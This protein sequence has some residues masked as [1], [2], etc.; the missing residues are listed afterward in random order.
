MRDRLCCTCADCYQAPSN[1][2]EHVTA[3][4]DVSATLDAAIGHVALA[5]VTEDIAPQPVVASVSPLSQSMMAVA[6]G[7]SLDTAG[8]VNPQCPITAV[9]ATAPQVVSE[10]AS[11]ASF[12]ERPDKLDKCWEQSLARVSKTVNCA[13]P[14]QTTD[15]VDRV[16]VSSKIKVRWE[17]DPPDIGAGGNVN[18][19]ATR[20]T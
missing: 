13:T 6:T 17:P 2:T 5:P 8:L 14:A 15:H 3:P 1:A 11:F 20:N 9:K 16:D 12:F 10:P 4:A 19:L 18:V 7:N